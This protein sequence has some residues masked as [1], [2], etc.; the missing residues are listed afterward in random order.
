MLPFRLLTLFTGEDAAVG[1]FVG[2]IVT[3]EVKCL[4]LLG[5]VATALRLLARSV[6]T[7]VGDLPDDISTLPFRL[8]TFFTG[9]CFFSGVVTFCGDLFGDFVEVLP[10]R[11]LAFFTGEDTIVSCF[12]GDFAGD[13]TFLDLVG[14]IIATALRLLTRFTGDVVTTLSLGDFFDSLSVNG[15]IG[16]GTTFS[17]DLLCDFTATLPLR[18]LTLFAGGDAVPFLGGDFAGVSTLDFVGEAVVTALRLLTRFTGDVTMALSWISLVVILTGDTIFFCTV[19][20]DFTFAF[21]LRLPILLARGDVAFSFLGDF[22]DGLLDLAGEDFAI[23]LLIKT[24][25]V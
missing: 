18:L 20:G 14:E 21:P 10:L 17:G 22:V 13:T 2:D 25:I 9:G 7:F 11:L 16:D 23:A 19:V 8:L 1:S 15:F 5:E 12:I 3:G 4:G 6:P 24:K